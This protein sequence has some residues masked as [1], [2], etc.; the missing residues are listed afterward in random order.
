ML[1][2]PATTIGPSPPEPGWITVSSQN[3]V[4]PPGHW[5][6]LFYV[7][8][9]QPKKPF[10]FEESVG[11]AHTSGGGA[12]QLGLHKLDDWLGN[13]RSHVAKAGCAWVAEAIDNRQYDDAQIL[14][15]LILARSSQ[16]GS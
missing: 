11:G 1:I 10:C 13:W 8:P 6:Y 2:K 9:E 5:F 15:C 7:V 4:D 3:N 16:L 12:I 14:I